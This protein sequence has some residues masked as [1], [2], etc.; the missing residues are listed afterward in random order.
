VKAAKNKKRTATIKRCRDCQ[1][2]PD[3]CGYWDMNQRKKENATYATENTEHNC[4]DF[5]QKEQIKCQ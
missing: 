4:P 5:E 3:A 1:H 2:Y